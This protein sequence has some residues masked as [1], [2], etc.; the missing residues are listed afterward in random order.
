M[1]SGVMAGVPVLL[2]GRTGW[3]AFIAALYWPLAALFGTA[4]AAA[5]ALICGLAAFPCDTEMANT[6]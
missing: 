2:S 4:V 6:K 3:S 5:V 1:V